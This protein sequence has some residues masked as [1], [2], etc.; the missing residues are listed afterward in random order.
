MVDPSG[1]PQSNP[2]NQNWV[3]DVCLN[4]LFSQLSSYNMNCIY[5]QFPGEYNYPIDPSVGCPHQKNGVAV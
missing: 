3:S 5:S 4:I 1:S 2:T